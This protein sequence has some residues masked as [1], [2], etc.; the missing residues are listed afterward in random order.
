MMM[1]ALRDKH[2]FGCG[3]VLQIT[4]LS[5]EALRYGRSHCMTKLPN[6]MH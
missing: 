2:R 4:A 1:A 6:A 3:I 5:W